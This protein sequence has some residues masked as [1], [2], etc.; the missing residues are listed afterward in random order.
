MTAGGRSEAGAFYLERALLAAGDDSPFV[1]RP[2]APAGVSTTALDGVAA[3]L[4][5]ETAGLGRS[6]RGQLAAYVAS[7]GGLLIAAGP[8]LDPAL[9]A[10]FLGS[11]SAPAPPGG[12]GA[13]TWSVTAARHPL[14]AAFDGLTGALG[15][16]RFRQAVRLGGAGGR[17]LAAFSDGAPALMEMERT[18]GRG[19]VIVFASDLNNE[20]NDFPRQP[21]FVPFVHEVVRYLGR[22]RRPLRERLVATAPPGVEPRPGAVIEP[23]AGGPLVLNV[24]PRE[25]DPSTLTPDEFQSRIRRSV[26][27]DSGAAPAPADAAGREAEQ[28]Y[29]WYLLLAMAVVLVAESWLGRTAA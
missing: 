25:S 18:A 29:W 28:R 14:F 15:Q 24:D 19:R 10:E 9:V 2:L 21:T 4:L 17:V 1:V 16:V 8:R 13:L 5:L 7:G 22:H 23:A 26:A 3:V 27:P 11:G 6:P 20:W 12:A